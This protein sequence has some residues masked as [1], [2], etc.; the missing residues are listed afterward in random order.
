MSDDLIAHNSRHKDIIFTYDKFNQ[1]FVY[2]TNLFSLEQVL[3]QDGWY[4]RI[5]DEEGNKV[6]TD[7][8]I[9][10]RDLLRKIQ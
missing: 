9:N 8:N 6:L 10:L 3:S 4:I 7:A 5:A 1:G 2:K